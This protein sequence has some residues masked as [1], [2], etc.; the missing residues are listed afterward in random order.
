VLFSAVTLILCDHGLD[1]NKAAD[2]AAAQAALRR[3]VHMKIEGQ[4]DVRVN[5]PRCSSG[6]RLFSDP[7]TQQSTSSRLK[8]HHPNHLFLQ[9]EVEGEEVSPGIKKGGRSDAG[10]SQRSELVVTAVRYPLIT[11][12]STF[13]GLES[14]TGTNTRASECWQRFQAVIDR[15]FCDLLRFPHLPVWRARRRKRR[16][17]LQQKRKKDIYRFRINVINI[18]KKK[19]V[20]QKL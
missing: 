20:N 8:A 7:A 15:D 10:T 6:H 11:S 5:L 4:E 18:N 9:V 19:Y 2:Q 3:H 1:F 14:P 16:K 13:S 12:Q 17:T